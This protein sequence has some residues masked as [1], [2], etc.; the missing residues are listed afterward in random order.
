MAIVIVGLMI[1]FVGG[2]YLRQLGQRRTNLKEIGAYY[3]NKK[4]ITAQQLNTCR[5][6][7][8]ILRMLRS[9]RMLQG[10]Q[11]IQGV[12]LGE[13]LFSQSSSSAQLVRNLRR[14]IRI[15]EL[16]ISDEQLNDIY[17]RSYTPAI[18]WFLLKTEAED[19]GF[20]ITTETA[21]E[22]LARLMPRIADDQSYA[23]V[24]QLITKE[25]FSTEEGILDIFSKLIA[26]L[27]YAQ[28]ICSNENIT[29][30]Q[31]MH[32]I[33]DAQQTVDVEFVKF[34]SELF[35]D[36]QDEPNHQQ[37]L[38]QFNRYKGRFAGR[39]T[40]ENPYG[41]GYK[42][43]DRARLEYLALLLDEVSEIIDEPT[44]E[45]TEF[46]YFRHRD[47]FTEQVASDANDPNSPSIESTK[48]YAE[49]SDAIFKGMLGARVITKANEIM[50]QAKEIL[51]APLMKLR[52]SSTVSDEQL[53][54]LAGDYGAVAKQLSKEHKVKL[55]S[56]Q[57]GLLS[58]EDM[59]SNQLLAS[60]YLE[61]YG[62]KPPDFINLI[63][64][65]KIIFAMEQFNSAELGPFDA[66][67]PRL[68]ENIGP[69]KDIAGSTMML[70]R[71]IEAQKA[72]EPGSIDTS[73][74]TK[75]VVFETPEGDDHKQIYSI[76][77]NV[78]KDL[79]KLSAME[80]TR[81]KAEEFAE[82]VGENGWEQTI[83]KFNELY[84]KPQSAQE[85]GSVE[86]AE[87][88]S[89]PFRLRSLSALRRISE[90]TI[91]ALAIQNKSD[92][93][94][95]SLTDT[96]TKEKLFID[97]LFSLVPADVNTI[98]NLPV[99]IEVKHEMS[100]YCIKS[101]SVNRIE[102]IEYEQRKAEN[103]YKQDRLQSESLAAVHFNPSNI[104]QRMNFK[105]AKQQEPDT[106]NN[107]AA[108]DGKI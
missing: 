42:L 96:L 62:H 107:S 51:E 71:V 68:Y 95:R 19:A 7:L 49:V 69:L 50:Q 56:G 85:E 13:L 33:S 9:D 48:S 79:K 45:E 105:L 91:D 30:K 67:K 15:N 32:T 88:T 97:Q 86:E 87:E 6:E 18:Y 25:G 24:M 60:S 78:I 98:G 40:Q 89:A 27:Q 103:A 102:Q 70:V 83:S 66:Q 28:I 46:Y 47:R 29:I 22:T 80:T 3:G 76:K 58:A 35:I 34:D 82:M 92:P 38:E 99:V 54:K 59:Q 37:M 4:P 108:E 52:T 72:C 41:F 14:F 84:G 44:Q 74:S 43:A 106:D 11:D 104:I 39:V 90:K 21:R 1:A 12:L 8:Q 20:K 75:A 53:K 10:S 31:L 2:S 101:I 57:T 73:Y 55:Y 23:E 17:R 26:V 100:C 16:R 77:E 65:P 61:G 64:L 94:G 36:T 81:E 93:A 63:R 5:R